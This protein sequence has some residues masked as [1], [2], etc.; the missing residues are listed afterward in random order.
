MYLI[1]AYFD[2]STY[3]QL[4]RIIDGIAAV[5]GLKFISGMRWNEIKTNTYENPFVKDIIE[6][7]TDD[8]YQ[9]QDFMDLSK[10][11]EELKY[12]P[13]YVHLDMSESGDKTGI[14]GIWVVGKKPKIENEDSSKEMFYRVAFNV[15][16]KAPRGKEISFDKNRS[17]VR[18][19]KKQ[20]F[21]I[22]GVSSDTYNAAQIQQQLTADGFNVETISVD[23]LDTQTKKCLPY[24]Y[25]K[26]LIYE[27]RLEV[28]EKCDLLTEEVIGLER[29]S[30]GH[31][32][33]PENGTYGSKD[34]VDAVCGAIWNASQH[35]DEFAYE[36]GEIYKNAAK[37]NVQQTLT[38]QEQFNKAF[39][40]ELISMFSKDAD[41][42]LKTLNENDYRRMGIMPP[43]NQA[44]FSDRIIIV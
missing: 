12:K 5:S 36:Y 33:H 17:F 22:K 27:K 26:S 4:K 2:E 15:S 24:E 40:D 25:F 32:N 14:A 34:S 20:N 21:N 1:T 37:F 11:P 29:E 3:R 44:S 7:G 10:I 28:Y 38:T 8:T 23:R 16:I 30:D 18:W 6:V 31:I 41:R 39:E 43:N 13:M 9:Y 42:Q 35:A 19:L